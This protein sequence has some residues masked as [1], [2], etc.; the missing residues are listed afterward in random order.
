MRSIH[1]IYLLISIYAQSCASN[2]TGKNAP[3]AVA[4]TAITAAPVRPDSFAVG[5]VID[6]ITCAADAG[7]SYAA[8]IPSTGNKKALPVIFF[9]DPHA[10]GSLP[11]HKYKALAD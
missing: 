7:Q 10:S 11:L 1:C 2:T 8:Y 4:D 3:V 5:K 9:F 6:T